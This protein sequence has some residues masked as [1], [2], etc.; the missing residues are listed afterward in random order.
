MSA[1]L[2]LPHL[3]AAA[4]TSAGWLP[5]PIDP[6]RYLPDEP[7]SEPAALPAA[8]A[9]VVSLA[10]YRK[11]TEKMLRRYLYASMLVGR[12]PSILNEPVSRGWASSRPVVTFEEAVIFVLDVENCLA[13]LGPLDRLLLAKAIVQE[14]S[15][16]EVALLLGIGVKRL[17]FCLGQALDRLTRIMLDADLLIMS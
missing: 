13:K 15:H 17:E 6:A 9:P 16:E 3:H 4:A 1:A 5:A 12:A 11:H 7:P 14:Y 2:L 8:P 10:F